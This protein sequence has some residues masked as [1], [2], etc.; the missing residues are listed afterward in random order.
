MQDRHAYLIMCHQ[1]IEQLKIL[2]S[3]LDYELNDIYIHADKKL[4][5]SDDEKNEISSSLKKSNCYFIKSQ[6]GAWGGDSLMKIEINLLKK[7]TEYEHKYYHLLSGADLPLKTQSYIHNI[8]KN[9]GR[10]YLGLD[11]EANETKNFLDR[12][13]YYYIFQYFIDKQCS[14]I[15]VKMRN[16]FIIVQKLIG[17]D[18]TR[19]ANFEYGKS[20]QWFS[21]THYTA[22]FIL[23]QYPLYKKYFIFSLIPDESFISTIIINSSLVDNLV[24]DSLRLIDWSRG[25]PYTFGK[26]D[27]DELINS[28]KLFARKFDINYDEE[29]IYKIYEFLKQAN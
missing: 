13:R 11:H 8:L 1:N 28:S 12:F 24:D 27:F 18:R 2:L 4:F 25:E 10:D 14:S 23:N 17:I 20:G 16:G 29:I 15:M 22:K 3:L 9:D 5:L 21:I 7:A 19:N 26:D 6:Y